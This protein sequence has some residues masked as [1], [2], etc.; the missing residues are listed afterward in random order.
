[1]CVEIHE[2]KRGIPKPPYSHITGDKD[3]ICVK[4]RAN[5]T[6]MYIAAPLRK[7]GAREITLREVR[8]RRQRR[9]RERAA[10]HANARPV[11]LRHLLPTLSPPTIAVARSRTIFSLVGLAALARIHSRFSRRST[12][13]HGPSVNRTERFTLRA[14]RR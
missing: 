13:H 14:R 3:Y 7:S 11:S 10:M 1:M 8:R 9:R 12:F 6:I 2:S 4:Y 5:V